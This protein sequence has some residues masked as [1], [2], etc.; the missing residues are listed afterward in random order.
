MFRQE[1]WLEIM[2][3]CLRRSL[4]HCCSPQLGLGVVRSA[5]SRSVD[6]RCIPPHEI[7]IPNPAH[8]L[9][10]QPQELCRSANRGLPPRHLPNHNQPVPITLTHLQHLPTLLEPVAASAA[11]KLLGGTFLLQSSGTFLFQRYR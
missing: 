5:T 7:P 1:R 4:Q 11:P 3:L 9:P 10:A 8:L 2:E 6:H